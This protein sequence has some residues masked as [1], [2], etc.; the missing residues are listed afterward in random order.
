MDDSLQFKASV[1][2][3]DIDREVGIVSLTLLYQLAGSRRP[4]GAQR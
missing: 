3:R 4:R 1:Y 2:S